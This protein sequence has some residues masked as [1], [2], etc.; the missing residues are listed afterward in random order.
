MNRKHLNYVVIIV[1]AL[2]GFVVASCGGNE[3]SSAADEPADAASQAPEPAE[4]TQNDEDT[5]GSAASESDDVSTDDEAPF[6]TAEAIG[7]TLGWRITGE[8]LEVELT[9]PT[10]GWIA[11][12]FKPSRGMKDAN[13]L[14]GYVD[15][16]EAVMTDQFGT[17]MIAHRRDEELGGAGHATVLSGSE[18]D[19]E[20]TIRFTIPLD[21]GDEYDQPL[22]AGETVRAILAYGPDD[23]DDTET[24]HE[25]RAG[26]DIEL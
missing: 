4:D 22:A 12:G 10:T 25:D 5:D 15:G 21:S 14:I 1:I 2:L 16:D 13:I 19:G 7:M 3:E 9:G 6:A 18:T 11:V 23:A 24:Y 20:T 26:L 8:D 17:T